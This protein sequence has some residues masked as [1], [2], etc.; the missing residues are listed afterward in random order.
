VPFT[1][2][3]VA[4]VMP[5]YRLLSRAHV[6]SAAVIGSMVPDFG[7][8]LPRY[9]ARWETHSV[10]ALFIFCLPVGLLTYW[11]TQWLIKPAVLEALPD[12]A[13][14]RLRAAHPAAS[15]SKIRT[16]FLVSGALL[17]GALTHLIWDGFTHEN[18]RAV[19]TIPLLG[20]YGPDY[21]GHPMHLYRWLQYSSSV[22][23]LLVVGAALVA[24]LRHAPIHSAP[25]AR[26]MQ[27]GERV[28]WWVLYGLPPVLF[29]AWAIS[30][31]ALTGMSWTANSWALGSLA[32][33]SI[34]GAAIS[35][36]LVSALIRLR[37]A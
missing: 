28:F 31:F 1:V 9:P 26:R 22:V 17:L 20:Y 36:L 7:L 27:R 18:A 12:G 10:L 34:R 13:Y 37:L 14:A 8:L 5:G 3:H 29:V 25:L 4:A 33:A 35:L 2:S 21:E 24:W 19:R 15:L 16:W 30:R 32:V 23:G 6:F 11:L